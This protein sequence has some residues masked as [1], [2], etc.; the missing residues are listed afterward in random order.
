[1]GGLSS[2]G[3]FN[4]AG[5]YYIRKQSR[6]LHLSI[7]NLPMVKGGGGGNGGGLPSRSVKLCTRR[8]RIW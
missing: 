6:L 8:N 3:L 1:M 7:K 4:L 5:E 2:C